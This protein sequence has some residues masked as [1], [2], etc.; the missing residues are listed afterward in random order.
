MARIR[1]LATTTL[2][3]A[4]VGA[5]LVG[6]ATPASADPA[7]GTYRTYVGVGS[8]TIQDVMNAA[9]GDVPG[10]TGVFTTV[11]SYNAFGSATI[12]TRASGPEFT[13]PQGSTEGRKALYASVNG[14]QYKGVD[15]TGQIDFA[16]SSSFT[17][18]TGALYVPFAR[19]G[20]S[21]AYKGGT[22]AK[23]GVLTT[24]QLTQIYSASA[25]V[26]INGVAV[27]GLLPQAGSGTRSFWLSALGLTEATVGTG[28]QTVGAEN[29]G[30]QIPAGTAT[31]ANII[32]FSGAQYVAQINGVQTNLRDGAKLGKPN[33]KTVYT[34]NAT[35]G[36]AAS[37]AGYFNTAPFGRSVYNV[38]DANAAAPL[39][40]LFITGTKTAPLCKTAGLSLS[41]KYGFAAI[42]TDKTGQTC[43]VAITGGYPAFP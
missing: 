29:D 17:S 4:A 12:K 11:A 1:A 27:T 40:A 23:V 13:R 7:A 2:V 31:T 15:V 9:A 37:S 5:A 28:V 38:V 35:S 30:R 10:K 19:D 18:G 33:G 16:R 21:Y 6:V 43:G 8:D 22:A 36:K 42:N 3:T 41:A 26:K 32:P 14:L 34:V 24:A 25:P 39:K 20:V